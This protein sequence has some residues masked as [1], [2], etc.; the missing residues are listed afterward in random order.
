MRVLWSMCVMMLCHDVVPSVVG[1][2]GCCVGPIG[3]H[4]P[5]PLCTATQVLTPG[6]GKPTI[7]ITSHHTQNYTHIYSYNRITHNHITHTITPHDPLPLPLPVTDD[8]YLPPSPSLCVVHVLV[9]GP[10][11]VSAVGV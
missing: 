11:W 2:G 1:C 4:V 9:H 3:G 7:T 10:L 8:P 6:T 5:R